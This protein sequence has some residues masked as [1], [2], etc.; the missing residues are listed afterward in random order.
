MLKSSLFPQACLLCSSKNGADFGICTNCL[1]DLP[2]H[3]PSHA[4]SC[5]QCGLLSFEGQLCGACIASPPDFDATKALFRYEYPISQ[6]LQ[7]YKYN[8]QLF[9]AETFAELMM[10]KIQAHNIDLIIPMPLHPSRLQE[11]GFNQSLEIARIISKRLKIKVNSQAVS[12]I[13]QSPPQASLPLKERVKNM[14][15]A[16][17]CH[18]D[19]SSLRIALIDDVM[20]TGASLNALAKAVKAK[21]AT[22]VECWLIARTLA[23]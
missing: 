20:T 15:G 1:N 22:H 4:A 3:S 9:L 7:Q 13:K 17:A 10:Q 19:L 8:Q 11:R 21:G 2:H 5:P 12:R 18:Q 6:V 14:K 16:F 23:K